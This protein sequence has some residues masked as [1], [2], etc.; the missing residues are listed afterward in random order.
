M[1][2]ADTTQKRI[3]YTERPP[4]PSPWW[5]VLTLSLLLAIPWRA[6]ADQYT[7]QIVGTA[8]PGVAQA[9]PGGADSVVATALSDT[10]SV[11]GTVRDGA[12]N[13]AALLFPTLTPLGTLTPGFDSFALAADGDTVGGYSFD[14]NGIN[15]AFQWT[16]AGGLVDINGGMLLSVATAVKGAF[17]GGFCVETTGGGARPCLWVSGLPQVLPTPSNLRGEGVGMNGTGALAG[18]YVAA[19]GETHALILDASMTPT[20]IHPPGAVASRA[21][22][23]T[24][25]N[26]VLGTALF[27]GGGSRIFQWESGTGAVVFDALP[28]YVFMEGR[29]LNASTS[30]GMGIRAA[31][32]QRA[33][34]CTNPTVCE[35]LSLLLTDLGG[36]TWVLYETVAINTSGQILAYGTR[37]GTADF[38]VLLSRVPPP[39]ATPPPAPAPKP[40][41]KKMRHEPK[42]GKEQGR[43]AGRS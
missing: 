29:D 8:A 40:K 11:V 17:L 16:Q 2:I 41:P 3:P 9:H 12:L 31:G 32:G 15:H 19:S 30:I 39:P 38:A 24:A 28:T 37:N 34:R 14:A 36:D 1:S 43:L 26:R 42:Q 22:A 18:S 10:G 25:T 7:L 35:D 5:T 4:M 21:I 13:V 6:Q 27:P 20:D 23:V 33:L